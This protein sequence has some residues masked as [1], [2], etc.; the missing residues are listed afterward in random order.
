MSRPSCPQGQV[1]TIRITCQDGSTPVDGM[2]GTTK[3]VVTTV[4]QPLPPPDGDWRPN[5]AYITNID[6]FKG[7]SFADPV[8]TCPPEYNGACPTSIKDEFGVIANARTAPLR[9]VVY[10]TEPPYNPTNPNFP[11]EF[12]Q[13]N[14]DCTVE[15]ST[16]NFIGAEFSTNVVT[17]Y[18]TLPYVVNTGYSVPSNVG[19][20][21]KNQAPSVP[22]F[23]SP[24]GYT[25]HSGFDLQ[26][27]SQRLDPVQT[28]ETVIECANACNTKGPECIGFNYRL[29]TRACQLVKKTPSTYSGAYRQYVTPP[30]AFQGVT[31]VDS[32]AYIRE[33]NLNP[34]V[35]TSN[36]TGTNMTH[37]GNLC[38]SAP[39][40]NADLTKLVTDGV[41]TSF[42]TAELESCAFCPVRSYNNGSITNEV[43]TFSG[44]YQENLLYKTDPG[45]S[46]YA[47][48]TGFYSVR[49]WLDDP[50][51][52]FGTQT[53][54]YSRDHGMFT[55]SNGKFYGTLI[56]PTSK[57]FNIDKLAVYEISPVTYVDNGYVFRSV[58]GGI[59]SRSEEDATATTTA[60]TQSNQR[61]VTTYSCTSGKLVGTKCVGGAVITAQRG[62][63]VYNKSVFIVTPLENSVAAFFS[64]IMPSGSKK[65]IDISGSKWAISLGAPSLTTAIKTSTQ[66]VIPLI[67]S[68]GYASNL[69]GGQF[70]LN[71][72][73]AGLRQGDFV[74]I[75]S[76][77]T[78]GITFKVIS[79]SS[80]MA[81]FEPKNI[82]QDF[83]SIEGKIIPQG[84]LIQS[85]VFKREFQYD[86]FSWYTEMEPGAWTELSLSNDIVKGLILETAV[87]NEP[88]GDPY[89]Q[90]G[91]FRTLPLQPASR[92][93]Y[94]TGG[95]DSGC[96]QYLLYGCYNR[97][98]NSCDTANGGV[99]T[100][101]VC[102]GTFKACVPDMETLKST[103]TPLVSNLSP[104]RVF[105]V[106]NPPGYSGLSHSYDPNMTDIKQTR[107]ST[108]F[109]PQTY[110]DPSGTYHS[111]VIPTD[112]KTLS[113]FPSWTQQRIQSQ[114][115]LIITTS[116]ATSSTGCPGGYYKE[117]ISQTEF[118]QICPAG[119]YCP[120]GHTDARPTQCDPGNYCPQMSSVQNQC[121]A[122]FYCD[123]PASQIACPLGFY[124]PVG[125]TRAISCDTEDTGDG[126]TQFTQTT[127]DIA[128]TTTPQTTITIPI[129]FTFVKSAV[130]GVEGIVGPLQYTNQDTTFSIVT[131][132]FWSATI[133]SGR[134]VT[135]QT[136][137]HYCPIQSIA[138]Q[139]CGVG[140]MCP[141]SSQDLYCPAGNYCSD[142]EGQGVF[143][144]EQCP[145]GYYYAPPEVGSGR[146]FYLGQTNTDGSHCYL[147]PNDTTGPNGNQSG[148]VC[149]DSANK[150]WS[151]YTG[152]CIRTC[153]AGSAPNADGTACVPCPDGYYT[154][155][156]GLPACIKCADNF[157]SESVA[158]DGVTRA[159][160]G[161]KKC[162]CTNQRAAVVQNGAVTSW[163]TLTN[164]TVAWNS[165]YNRCEV[166]CSSGYKPFWSDCVVDKVSATR[167]DTLICP[168]NSSEVTKY[169][170][171]CYSCAG[172]T[173]NLPPDE[174]DDCYMGFCTSGKRYKWPNGSGPQFTL[175]IQ[176][177]ICSYNVI[178]YNCP[179]GACMD[180]PQVTYPKPANVYCPPCFILKASGQCAFNDPTTQ[181][182]C[183]T[184]PPSQTNRYYT[185]NNQTYEIY[186]NAPSSSYCNIKTEVELPQPSPWGND[187]LFDSKSEDTGISWVLQHLSSMTPRDGSVICIPGKVCFTGP[188]TNG[189]S[190]D[191]SVTAGAD[192]PAG[193]YCISTDRAPQVCPAGKYCP[194]GSSLPRDCSLGDYCPEGSAQANRC[195]AGNYCPSPGIINYC[196]AGT[197]SGTVGATTASTCVTCTDGNYCPDRSTQP[198]PCSDG[199]YCPIGTGASNRSSRSCANGY[200]CPTTRSQHRCPAGVVCQSGSSTNYGSRICP[201]TQQPSADYST[202]EN[203]P[204][205][206]TNYIWDQTTAD[207][208]STV[209]LPLSIN[210]G[211]GTYTPIRFVNLVFSNG[212]SF[213]LGKQ[214]VAETS[215]GLKITGTVSNFN[216]T[217]VWVTVTGY[218]GTGTGTLWTIKPSGCDTISACQGHMTNSSDY[219]T[220]Q[221]CPLPAAGYRWERDNGCETVQCTDG[222]VP[223]ADLRTCTLSAPPTCTTNMD[224]QGLV[225]NGLSPYG[226]MCSAG[227]CTSCVPGTICATCPSST[228]V[229]NG[230]SCTGGDSGKYWN[231][232]AFMSCSPRCTGG[233]YESTACTP[234]TN[235]VCSPCRASCGSGTFESTA[236]TS[237]SDRVC[238]TCSESMVG[239][240]V[241]AACTPTT[242][243]QFTPIVCPSGST[244]TNIDPG[245]S[246]RVG[247]RM[248]TADIPPTIIPAGQACPPGQSIVNGVCNACP[249]GY[250]YNSLTKNCYALLDCAPP[251]TAGT[252]ESTAC[253]Q[254]TDR[255]CSPCR[256]CA[257]GTQEI[258]ACTSTTNR[259]CTCPAGQYKVNGVCTQCPSGQYML[260]GVC[261][262][263]RGTCG[264][265]NYESTAC[266][267][268]TNRVCSPCSTTTCPSGTFQ[269]S[270]CTSTA[271]R[272]CTP[273]GA[274]CAAGLYQV[275][276]CTTTADRVCAGC[277][278]T[279]G[280]GTYQTVAC[281]STT[282]RVCTS[283]TVCGGSTPYESSA[284]TSTS[285]RVCSACPTSTPYWNGSSCTTC[286]S[287][288]PYWNGTACGNCPTGQWSDNGTCRTCSEPS[289]TQWVSTKCTATTNT[290]F[291]PLA[292]DAGYSATDFDQGSSSRVGYR[293]C[294]ANAPPTPVPSTQTCPEGQ[295]NG[296]QGCIVCGDGYAYN[297]LNK[298]CY[299]LL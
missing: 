104:I 132:Q 261:T 25:E 201:R 64:Q 118:C 293:T 188:L 35:R 43:G 246:S 262:A 193:Y 97:E 23:T 271:D 217:E 10:L 4:C 31:D 157:R 165:K 241:S 89:E 247:S 18:D 123:T 96:S 230:V 39:A 155:V 111:N 209:M 71:V 203:C 198:I 69:P 65:Y 207:S 66:T 242:N 101:P 140:H 166:T 169:N 3:P 181:T 143:A 269:S 67:S 91:L 136:R 55:F 14:L 158:A 105:R 214:V 127:A 197:F 226:L 263:C 6:N 121:Q 125:S 277:S 163:E 60:A 232:S 266:T 87:E 159:M 103:F 70:S 243:T 195:P 295:Y 215:N 1:G 297:P 220:C 211:T 267:P 76:S 218:T 172:L 244:A 206:T 52:I 152:S 131:P 116:L 24:P 177:R 17:E 160:S 176:K 204:P 106:D 128:A 219:M 62:T 239:Q 161:A 29:M 40:C 19:V 189:P 51:T 107:W 45:E 48:E 153:D 255:V 98:H 150:N 175:N 202:C 130:I 112:P 114:Q 178:P 228:P 33:E 298:Q 2:C 194:T 134:Q 168:G 167:A 92:A 283:C 28:K 221:A 288:S 290:Q 270:A 120:G 259:E 162:K 222:Q 245:S 93:S 22:E 234:T 141:T 61:S 32:F 86:M 280:T 12:V 117:F 212:S 94:T 77:N 82:N 200:Y 249:S 5:N 90:Y 73:A 68:G 291:S 272:V 137:A 285:N 75:A 58:I 144:G 275:S 237:I 292:C 186:S 49:L 30:P 88:M 9:D 276:A 183:Y 7:A 205:L 100:G 151:P 8:T 164:G 44:N 84:S 182:G 119:Y 184:C 250:G 110:Q 274:P 56:A 26:H 187:S 78:Y 240:I 210:A 185:W 253:T 20:F 254:T 148:C 282:N 248:C 129:S 99:L 59:I 286:P 174:P 108:L 265:G 72:T 264:S 81:T 38:S 235:R 173:A 46:S 258:T 223:S 191:Q 142:P 47:L 231:G 190:K 138:P 11:P 256:T 294:V 36:P 41:V 225:A 80:T 268:T 208:S 85:V 50:Y 115:Y 192:C 296:L 156:A 227:K 289:Y 279:C 147:C 180:F 273:C 224:C 196:P 251:C 54:Y 16:C 170:N 287:S 252:Y 83:P 57:S 233:T 109:I 79:A 34:E 154:D 15:G 146:I 13:A 27:D 122:G 74:S 95:C 133:P 124:C 229:W 236:C 139:R 278:G 63:P 260:N 281:T 21:I 257:T 149:V 37:E 126:T 179:S 53:I 299:P 102:S 199:E 145:A 284:C 171:A 135:V 238:T 213:T 42:S 113:Y 216:P